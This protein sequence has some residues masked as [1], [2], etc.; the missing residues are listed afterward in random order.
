MKNRAFV[1]ALS[2][3]LCLAAAL[4]ASARPRETRRDRIEKEQEEAAGLE[5]KA[6]RFQVSDGASGALV[7]KEYVANPDAKGEPSLVVVIGGKDAASGGRK[8]AGLAEGLVPLLDW[9]RTKWQGGKVVVLVPTLSRAPVGGGRGGPNGG[10]AAATGADRLPKL[11]RE[12]AATNGVAAAR[13]FAA[14]FS[15]GGEVVWGLLDSD[16]TLFARAVVVGAKGDP[17]RTADVGAEV[18]ALHG[19][20]DAV[21]APALARAMVDAVNARHPGRASLETFKG[22]GHEES[23]EAAYARRETWDRLLRP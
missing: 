4:P 20:N 18:F 9:S 21:V 12:R 14:G 13:V 22:K 6:A 10:G 2:S 15:M 23:A 8:P 3:L 17:E 19:E 16:P 5:R 1:L 7:W 11:V